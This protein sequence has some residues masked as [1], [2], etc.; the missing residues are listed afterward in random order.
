MTVEDKEEKEAADF[1]KKTS[2]T[3]NKQ[4]NKKMK[5]NVGGNVLDLDYLYYNVS[6]PSELN[7]TI[8]NFI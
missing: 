7:E 5:K 1:S 2:F 6:P 4:S 3:N 8:S